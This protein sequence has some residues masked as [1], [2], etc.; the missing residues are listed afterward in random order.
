MLYQSPADFC[1]R[2]AEAHSNGKVDGFGGES[3]VDSVTVVS[4]APDTARIDALWYTYGHDPDSGFYD[5]FE[6]TAFVL[7]KRHDG[8]HLHSEENLGYE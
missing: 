5:V 8:W 6:R 3:S 1:A 7:V 2:Y 4:E